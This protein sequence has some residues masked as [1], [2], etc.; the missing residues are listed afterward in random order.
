MNATNGDL[1]DQTMQKTYLWISDLMK[2]LHWQDRH[3]AY[4]ALRAVLQTL[5]DRLTVE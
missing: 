2:E 4:L 5:R 3:K 1:F